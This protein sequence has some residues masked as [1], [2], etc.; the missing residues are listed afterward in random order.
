MTTEKPSNYEQVLERILIKF[1]QEE[2]LSEEAI[3]AAIERANEYI[4]AA[5]EL[6]EDELSLIKK[7]LKRD[8]QAFAE[9]MAQAD[10]EP[11]VWL[12]T[13][14]E[15][16]WQGLADITD[17]TQLEWRELS[18]DLAHDGIYRAHEWVGLG[19]LCCTKCKHEQEIYH[20]T[21]LETCIQC[22]NDTFLRRP[23]KP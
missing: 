5:E 16:I 18:E 3:D 1:K 14:T 8:L 21:K 2:H 17:K 6:T 9:K 12:G 20:P 4:N 15:S 23:F 11:S 7:Y 19:V 10:D 13:L 22:G